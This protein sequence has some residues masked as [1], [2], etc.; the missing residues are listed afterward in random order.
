MLTSIEKE[1][2]KNRAALKPKT[3][4][5]L[6][7]RIA[8]KAKNRLS[9]LDD[10]NRALCSIPEKNAKRALD[11]QM[12]AAIFRLTENMIHILGYAPVED[13]PQGTRFVIRSEEIISR[14][15]NSEKF[16]VI[17]ETPTPIDEAR[18]FLLKEHLE[19]LQKFANPEIREHMKLNGNVYDGPK[20][21]SNNAASQAGYNLFRKW[22][23]PK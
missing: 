13:G 2:L 9:E 20:G 7:Y 14:D 19:K 6:D 1:Q 5:N 10:I 21:F 22:Q 11:D 16:E 23:E 4:A 3:R 15:D 8:Q 12:V 18:H 17:R